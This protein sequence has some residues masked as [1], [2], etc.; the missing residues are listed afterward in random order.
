MSSWH[1]K[2]N[3]RTGMEEEGVEADR[4]SGKLGGMGMSLRENWG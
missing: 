4:N 2:Q 3:R 1:E